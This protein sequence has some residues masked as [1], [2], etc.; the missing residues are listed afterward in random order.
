M[1]R[2]DRLGA[3]VIGMGV[4]LTITDLVERLRLA[5]SAAEASG[6]GEGARSVFLAERPAPTDG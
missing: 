4:F 3:L 1:R 2:F 6:V 5:E